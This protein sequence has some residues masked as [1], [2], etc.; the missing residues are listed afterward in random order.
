MFYNWI[1]RWNCL[2]FSDAA[3]ESEKARVQHLLRV[4]TSDDLVLDLV[5]S[6]GH[7][8]LLDLSLLRLRIFPGLCLGLRVDWLQVQAVLRLTR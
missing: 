7:E 4:L 5:V 1:N 3:S 8:I 6:F 2:K